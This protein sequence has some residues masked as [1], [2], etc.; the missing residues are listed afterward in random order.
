MSKGGERA[1][2][3]WVA[4]GVVNLALC[5][6]ALG[7]FLLVRWHSDD[8]DCTPASRPYGA[9]S[10]A[11]ERHTRHGYEYIVWN[12]RDGTPLFDYKH[13]RAAVAF[14][15]DGIPVASV[16]C[17]DAQRLAAGWPLTNDTQP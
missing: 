7:G 6:V 5:A 16:D 11:F 15:E 14:S 9:D 12:Y 4:A 10:I 3:P 17:L 2:S 8:R 13:K 1:T